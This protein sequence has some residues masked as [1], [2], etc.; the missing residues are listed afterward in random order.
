MNTEETTKVTYDT[1]QAAAN[2]YVLNHNALE[3]TDHLAEQYR[4]VEARKQSNTVLRERLQSTVDTV[5]EFIRNCYSEGAT[6]DDIKELADELD[7]ELTKDVTVTIKAEVTVE[8]TVPLDFDVDD[9]QDHMFSI[10]VE[11]NYRN[12][13][14]TWDSDSIEID[15]FSAEEN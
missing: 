9:I 8:L 1:N 2:T 13:E 10:N 12:D 14:I 7:I 6:P 15:D 11:S 4:V 5:T 3:V